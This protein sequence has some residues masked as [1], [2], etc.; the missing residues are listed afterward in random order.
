MNEHDA[1]TRAI[2]LAR[3]YAPKAPFGAV[4][5]D[6]ANDILVGEGFN[7]SADGPIWHGEL[8]AIAKFSRQPVCPWEDL[9]LF[10]T[11]EPCPMCQGA[12]LWAGIPQVVFGVSIEDLC[13]LGWNQIE[14]GAKDIV[15]RAPFAQCEL[16][17]GVL[18][19]ECLELFRQA[20]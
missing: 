19:D 18:R 4:L 10:T 13:S 6:R 1:M 14:I 20:R 2:T 15:S 8:D 7:H 17:G 16:R 12:I 5:W 3:E 11:A 9:T